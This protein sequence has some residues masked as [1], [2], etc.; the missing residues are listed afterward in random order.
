MLVVSVIGLI[1]TALLRDHTNQDISAE[2]ENV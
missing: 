2:Y 1:A